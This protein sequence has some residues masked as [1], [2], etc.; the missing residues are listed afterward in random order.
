V[1]V[2]KDEKFLGLAEEAP[3]AIYPLFSQTP[4][5]GFFVLVRSREGAEASVERVRRVVRDLDPE[6]ALS[7]V[8]TLENRLSETVA[9]PRF[10]MTLF[11]LFAVL[12]LGLAAVGIYGLMSQAV[13]QRTRELGLRMSLGARPSDVLSLVL[14]EGAR[15]SGLG[16]VIGIVL[17]IA[18]ARAFESFLFG[19]E[20]LDPPTL[21][22]VVVVAGAA[23]LLA[24]YVPARRASRIDPIQ[25]LRL[26]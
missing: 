18:V 15:L 10:T 24:S 19:I 26:E 23:G 25:S 2:V 22:A 4:F 6:L 7:E 21:A 5:S 9:E 16:I 13:G 14:G 12:A 20:K 17:A 8:T 3:P 11:A 1:G